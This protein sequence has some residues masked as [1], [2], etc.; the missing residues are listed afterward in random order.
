MQRE[1]LKHLQKAILPKDSV[2]ENPKADLT[3][4]MENGDSGQQWEFRGQEL[5]N[6]DPAC[7]PENHD[8]QLS[9]SSLRKQRLGLERVS[10]VVK[11][12]S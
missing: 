8:K 7:I 3:L 1:P 4:V 2:Q 12:M 6:T 5:Y 11:P 9:P 10:L